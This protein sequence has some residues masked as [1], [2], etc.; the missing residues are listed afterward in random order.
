MSIEVT[1]SAFRRVSELLKLENSPDRVFRIEVSGGGCSGLAYNFS[2]TPSIDI[3]EDDIV[4]RKDEVLV[5]ID[6]LS[7]QYM[8]DSVL[9]FI[10]ELGNSYFEIRNPKAKTKCGCGNSF[11]I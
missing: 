3:A 1:D 2:I 9:D 4:V 11:S 7:G 6:S 8:S 5:V 10:E